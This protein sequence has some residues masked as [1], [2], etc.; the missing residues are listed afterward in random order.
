MIND[1]FTG[2]HTLA[3][4]DCAELLLQVE[5]FVKDLK[6]PV[7]IYNT[8]TVIIGL[9]SARQPIITIYTSCL[10]RW[11]TTKDDFITFRNRLRLMQK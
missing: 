10:I 2:S 6:N 1:L 7:T 3:H 8:T 9:S 5:E 4:S 11:D